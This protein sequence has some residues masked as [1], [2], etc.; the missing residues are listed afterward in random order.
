MHMIYDQGL[1]QTTGREHYCQYIVPDHEISM[2]GK[3]K[4]DSRY[5]IQNHVRL[6][7]G[8]V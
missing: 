1:L 3:K 4:D 7:D 5:Q 6:E 8:Q 2:G